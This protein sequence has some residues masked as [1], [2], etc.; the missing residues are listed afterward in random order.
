ME[1]RQC[2]QVILGVDHIEAVLCGADQTLQEHACHEA[3]LADHGGVIVA[4]KDTPDL[5]SRLVVPVVR[6]LVIVD[7]QTVPVIQ[8]GIGHRLDDAGG[9]EGMQAIFIPL[10]EHKGL[11][12]H[13][14]HCAKAQQCGRHGADARLHIDGIG[15]YIFGGTNAHLEAILEGRDRMVKVAVVFHDIAVDMSVHACGAAQ[16]IAAHDG[17]LCPQ[18]DE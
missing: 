2:P 1:G 7:D 17:Y 14:C 6:G 15:S 13:N 3:P 18:T 5:I 4:I 8:A 11:A 12:L 16:Q 9:M 10:A